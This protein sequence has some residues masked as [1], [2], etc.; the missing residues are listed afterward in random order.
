[1]CLNNNI[2]IVTPSSIKV[3]NADCQDMRYK[4]FV[5]GVE[6]FEFKTVNNLFE[7]I[8]KGISGYGK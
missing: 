2:E 1:M 3:T 8:S 6:H 7:L 5:D 4:S